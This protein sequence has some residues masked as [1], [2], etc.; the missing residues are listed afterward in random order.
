MRDL[1]TVV[2]IKDNGGTRSGLDRRSSFAPRYFPEKRLGQDRRIVLD[3]RIREEDLMNLMVS[4]EPKRDTDRY[5]ELLRIR[6]MFFFGPLLSLSM[7]AIIM[8]SVTFLFG[9]I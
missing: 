5:L 1:C 2:L 7:W 4:L 9:V 8:S 6:R 3:R